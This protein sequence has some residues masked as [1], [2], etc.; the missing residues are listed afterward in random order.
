L[1]SDKAIFFITP[2]LLG[3][4]GQDLDSPASQVVEHSNMADTQPKLWP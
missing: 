1:T 2:L 4:D 3:N